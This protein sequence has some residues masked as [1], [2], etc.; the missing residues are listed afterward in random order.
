MKRLQGIIP[1]LVTPLKSRGE[2]DRAGLKKLLER[3]LEGGVQGVFVLGTTG[4]APALNYRLRYELVETT[5]EFVAGRVPVLVGVSD[6]SLTE[7]IELAHYAQGSGATAVVAAPPYY[8]PCGPAQIVRYYQE[9]ADEAT[10]PLLLYNM[11][12][13][14]GVKLDN[15]MVGALAPHQNVIGLKDTSG[16]LATFHKFLELKELRPDWSFFIGPEG[17]LA[18]SLRAGGDG[19][20]NGGSQLHPEL[21][22]ALFAAFQS[23]AAAEVSRL[24]DKIAQLRRIYTLDQAGL[25]VARGIKCALQWL[26]ICEAHVCEPFAPYSTEQAEDVRAILESLEL[27]RP[28]RE[29]ILARP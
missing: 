10:L 6:T 9:L 22:T 7:A 16:D 18:E 29:S 20:V 14:T 26:G 25:G 27:W 1:P 3:V 12:A 11:P 8:F 2:L 21:F 17:L 19:G 13:C 5:C 28:E 24:Q 23:G 4:E 15:E